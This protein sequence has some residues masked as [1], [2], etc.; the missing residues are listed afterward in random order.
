MQFSA[1]VA[2]AVA[3]IDSN[4]VLVLNPVDRCF[5]LVEHAPLP[6]FDAIVGPRGDSDDSVTSKRLSLCACDNCIVLLWPFSG[7]SSLI[8]R[9]D[10]LLQLHLRAPQCCFALLIL[11][12][13]G[14]GVNKIPGK[15]DNQKSPKSRWAVKA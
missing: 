5:R 10:A 6:P 4:A 3:R 1:I 9:Y 7:F 2:G 14:D 13:F 15:Q 11:S 8:F 12:S